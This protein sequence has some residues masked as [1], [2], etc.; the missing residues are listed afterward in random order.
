MEYD[1]D[2]GINLR[3][4][5]PVDKYK[6]P[7]NFIRIFEILGI[8]HNTVNQDIEGIYQNTSIQ[9]QQDSYEN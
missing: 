2:H 1:K 6:K 5:A 8:G 7:W 9:K 3:R 4:R